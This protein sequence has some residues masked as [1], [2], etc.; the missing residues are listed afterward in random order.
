[1]LN[2]IKAIKQNVH[3]H[4]RP[5]IIASAVTGVVV[6]AVVTRKLTLPVDLDV[7]F[8]LSTWIDTLDQAGMNVYV[9]PKVMHEEFEKF[10]NA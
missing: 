1:M 3:N 6:G 9:M 10:L 2:P 4:P 8:P 7:D 5:Y